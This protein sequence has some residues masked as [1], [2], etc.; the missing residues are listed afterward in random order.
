MRA[1]TRTAILAVFLASMAGCAVTPQKPQ[2][3]VVEPAARITRP[4]PDKAL[5]YF[6]R[7]SKLGWPVPSPIFDGDQHIG[8]LVL[9][10]DFKKNTQLKAYMAYE[11]TPGKHL[12]MV[13]GENADFVPAEVSAGKTYFIHV[14]PVMGVWKARFYMSPQ[15]GQLPQHE[16]DEV[17]ASGRQL[18]L[19]E[20]GVQFVKDNAEDIKK[21]K[22][23][24][25]QKYQARPANERLELRPEDGR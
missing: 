17:I 15:Q 25:W 24:W 22:A 19:T 18:K 6:V 21:V 1:V 14:R 23:E 9:D 7:T 11:A 8:T 13:Y 20:E 16:L 12:F 10:W 2:A 4:A 3:S 5:V